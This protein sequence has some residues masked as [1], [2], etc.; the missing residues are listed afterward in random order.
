MAMIIC[1][2]CKLRI[3]DKTTECMGCGFPTNRI[4]TEP[5]E[6][7]KPVPALADNPAV[8]PEVIKIEP[9]D[10]QIITEAKPVKKKSSVKWVFIVIAAALLIFIINRG[11]SNDPDLESVA[12][13]ETGEP[14]SKKNTEESLFFDSCK[15][16]KYDN[17]DIMKTSDNG[18]KVVFCVPEF[19]SESH[20]LSDVFS[21]YVIFSKNIYDNF[22]YDYISFYVFLIS[23]DA[24]GNQ[25]KQNDLNFTMNRS[26]YETYTW[27]NLK[28]ISIYDSFRNSCSTFDIDK[29]LE[30]GIDPKK[31]YYKGN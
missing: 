8:P 12:E 5:P 3:S 15:S 10:S 19:F 27:E 18:L 14:E 28:Y 1:P 13:V 11:I 26:E 23:T 9:Q 7:P 17:L 2:R 22:D 24:K 4:M 6:A 16:C 21:D 31:V 20:L 25:L 29:R 30:N